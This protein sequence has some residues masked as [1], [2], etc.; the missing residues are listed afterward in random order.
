M[1]FF[2]TLLK[3][4]GGILLVAISVALSVAVVL[5]AILIIVYSVVYVL[6]FFGIAISDPILV[7]KGWGNSLKS[8]LDKKRNK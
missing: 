8:A 3:L 2:L 6:R 1:Y 7:I 4:L 5:T